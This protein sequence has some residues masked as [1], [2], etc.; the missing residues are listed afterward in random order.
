MDDRELRR[1]IKKAFDAE[2]I[3]IPFPHM[4]LYVGEASKSFLTQQIELD[5][6]VQSD[7]RKTDAIAPTARQIRPTV[8]KADTEADTDGGYE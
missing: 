6:L 1:R 3:E 4:S 7:A 8:G 2:G 5:S